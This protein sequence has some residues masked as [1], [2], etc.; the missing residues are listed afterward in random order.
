MVTHSFM[1]NEVTIAQRSYRYL[2]YL[3]S[4]YCFFFILPSLLLKKMMA[5]PYFGVI[6]VSILFTGTY[7]ML[8]DII[9]E[10]YGMREARKVLFSALVSYT[11]FVFIMQGVIAIPSPQAYKVLWSTTQDKNAYEY[12]FSNL[13]LVWVSV[14]ICALFANSF[15]I[16]FLSKWKI[17]LHGKYFWLRSVCTSFFAA[18]F[19]SVISNL[20]S[21]GF[22]MGI[23]KI[24]YF[25]ELVLVSVSAKLITLIFFA[26]PASFVCAFLKK[27]ENID[28]Y[29]FEL[30][31]NP[32]KI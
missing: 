1:Q 8:L 31:F 16:I 29:D 4:L 13:Y 22:F 10:V 23:S 7:F 24:A 15:N 17:L 2:P 11:F 14:V 18:L 28:V 5:I 26:Y 32:F 9:T 12:I 19:Y 25:I 30:S 3:T 21:F 27:K 6:P 20:F